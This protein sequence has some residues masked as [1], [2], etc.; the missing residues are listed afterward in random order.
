MLVDTANSRSLTKLL[1]KSTRVSTCL[2][3]SMK[4]TDHDEATVAAEAAEA[5]V[6]MVE[7]VAVAA[8]AMVETVVAAAVA[9][10]VATEEA[11]VAA[12]MT[13]A[14]VADTRFQT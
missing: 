8:V 14:V 4:T 3:K 11:V 9:M 1:K 10:V 6:A 2:L 7:T 13:K 5:A 12:T